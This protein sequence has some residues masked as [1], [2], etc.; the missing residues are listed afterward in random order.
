[1][2]RHQ[3]RM[4]ID[5]WTNIRPRIEAKMLQK[6]LSAQEIVNMLLATHPDLYPEEQARIQAQLNLSSTVHSEDLEQDEEEEIGEA[7]L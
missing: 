4:R 6:K 2:A 1:M 7:Y 3:D 5:V